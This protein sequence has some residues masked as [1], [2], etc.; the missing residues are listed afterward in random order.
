MTVPNPAHHSIHGTPAAPSSTTSQLLT[1]FSTLS[2]EPVA[3]PTSA[4]SSPPCPISTLPTEL[5]SEILLLTALADIASF[6]RLSLVCKRLAYLI[7]AEDAIWKH[8]CLGSK[9]GFAGMHYSF[10][11]PL[12]S[13][14]N[15]LPILL[16]ATAATI[17]PT[18]L[19]ALTLPLSP[20]Y[21]TYATMF[22]S[23]PRLRFSGVYISTVNYTRPGASSPTNTSWNS[24]IHI[25]TYYR[26]LRFFR[27]GTCASLL[28]TSEP[29][30]VVP[31]MTKEHLH[32]HHGASSALPSAVMRDARRGRWKL[33]GRPALVDAP[34]TEF[35]T[36][37]AHESSGGANA[38]NRGR[39]LRNSDEEEGN[40]SIE[41]EGPSSD[42]KYVYCMQLAL[43]SGGPR[44][45]PGTRNNKLVWRAFWSWNRLTDDWA[46]FGLRND[47]AFWWS[48][49]RGFGL[50][51]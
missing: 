50:G 16:S 26:Y 35:E 42:G 21:P 31:Y 32:A 17:I 49:V 29:S 34:E 1:S 46:E 44:K 41:T 43:R 36:G 5:L 2:I 24:P 33:S 3:P 7:S 38:A 12:P 23:R 45:G 9:F 4:S 6:S 39:K 15:N 8:I 19:S 25:V 51:E 11:C 40:L 47:R 18:P 30:D 48:R 14:S 28:T 13:T 37:N 27:D 22:H 10:A 20:T